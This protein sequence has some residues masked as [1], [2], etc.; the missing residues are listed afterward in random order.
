IIVISLIN[1]LIE[2]AWNS[3]VQA[4]SFLLDNNNQ[5]VVI[6]MAD[7]IE[8]QDFARNEYLTWLFNNSYSA[9]ISG[10]QTGKASVAK[11]KL[12]IGTSKRFEINSSLKNAANYD[13]TIEN[14]DNQIVVGE[15]GNVIYHDLK[16]LKNQNKESDYSSYIGYL[17]RELKEQQKTACVIG[18]GDTDIMNRSSV[19]IAMDELGIVHAGD[20]ENT[21]VSDISFPGGKRTDYTKLMSLY[22]K[23]AA[24]ND[25]IIIDTGD[26]SRLDY[27][28]NQLSKSE[29]DNL[30]AA[31]IN[32]ISNFSNAIIE[33]SK[34]EIVFIM[35]S[36]FPSKN[37]LESGLKLTPM[38]VYENKGEGLYYSHN[39][40]RTGIITN[41]DIA[42]FLL[43]KL[44]GTRKSSLRE[45][46]SEAPL[47]NILSLTRKLLNIS[48]MRLPVLTWY[49]IFEIICATAGLIY[50][51]SLSK[52][53]Q[54]LMK[55]VKI[56]ML[57]NIVAPVVLLYMSAFE[58]NSTMVYF[59]LFII[60]SFI[61]A[62]ILF[63][64]IKR[65]VGQFICAALLVNG[66]IIVDLIRGSAM[67][68][69]SV[70][71]YDP[72]IGARF[73]GI[74]N[75]FAGVF[76]G[77]GILLA[78]CLLQRYHAFAKRK[79]KTTTILLILYSGIQLCIM[80][81][82]FSGANFGGTIAG[83][84]GYFFFYSS[85][86]QRKITII[87]LFLMALI[88]FMALSSIVVLDLLN[89]NSTTHVGK[90]IT[91]IKD[92][93]PKVLYSTIERKATMNLRLMKYTIWT[94]V[95]LCIILI[96][97]IMF[98]KP[99]RL[100]HGI[101]KKYRYFTAAWLGISA[102]SIAGLIVNDS[103]IVMAATAM[104]FTGYTIL[105]MCLEEMEGLN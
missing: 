24:A 90:F 80:G 49:A 92:N 43:E 78:G 35:L 40:K 59:G 1:V 34:Q 103:G 39:T 75:E 67:M 96:I 73:Y 20:V 10:R 63:L 84:V 19:L 29:Y 94:K 58:I 42:D 77:S 14:L 69:N 85:V 88:I 83:V 100:L 52:K 23:F 79:P 38:V 62:T 70:F 8:L 95:L 56:T 36:A 53:K 61:I 2:E 22:K 86:K 60:I 93:G 76:I 102:G 37:N 27:Y 31:A 71:G 17:G 105:Y 44:T 68:K 89:P 74:G 65:T 12:A 21:T 64:L 82:P 9:L 66:S 104:I 6:L 55:I 48:V 18:N 47:W 87:Q 72:I 13:E 57:V 45:V 26:L 16:G 41:L 25:L 5:K 28:K 91:E 97:T 15:N 30:K 7:H 46:H 3:K 54:L 11:A 32:N 4:S 101:F 81:M 99:V 33:S 51:L 98:F 50:M